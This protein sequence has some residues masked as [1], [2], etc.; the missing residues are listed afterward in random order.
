MPLILKLS[1]PKKNM[2]DNELNLNKLK[3]NKLLSR[4]QLYKSL[5]GGWK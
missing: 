4:V 1:M 5:G 3:Q 2:L